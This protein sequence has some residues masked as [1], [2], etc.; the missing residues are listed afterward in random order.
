M[1]GETFAVKLAK[2][3]PI[4]N[5]AWMPSTDKSVFCVISGFVPPRAALFNSKSDL[6][7]DFG[8][9]SLNYIYFNPF[10]NLLALAGLGNMRGGVQVWDMGQKVKLVEINCPETTELS[11]C[12]DGQH[13]L[14]STT[15]P[16]LRVGNGFRI[17]TYSGQK[18]HEEIYAN[19]VELYKIMWQPMP[20]VFT[21]PSIVTKTGAPLKPKKA[22]PK[23]QKYVPPG[24]RKEQQRAEVIKQGQRQAR[25]GGGGEA[26]APGPALSEK[27]KRIKG[28]EKKLEQIQKLKDMRDSGKELEKNQ[29]AKI[30]KQDELEQELEEALED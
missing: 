8:E 10:G 2:E 6:I 17:W 30:L 21:E 24:L 27:E 5:V 23:P 29:L 1:S 7:F 25:G 11:W 26:K 19:N 12:A 3:G 18:I 28:L 13:I 9:A 16:R 14:T 20:G 15:S 22:E 4:H